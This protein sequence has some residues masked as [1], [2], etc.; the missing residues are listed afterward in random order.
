MIT[1][2]LSNRYLIGLGNISAYTYLIH[3]V[4]TQYTTFALNYF[5]ITG[6]GI[7]TLA[8]FFE[9]AATLIATKIYVNL[10]KKYKILRISERFSSVKA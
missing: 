8:I 3:F 7:W 1:K 5:D 4:F 6:R 9:F 2:L 10:E